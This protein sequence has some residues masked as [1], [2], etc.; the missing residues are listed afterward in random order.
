MNIF[1]TAAQIYQVPIL[2]VY[3]IEHI[4]KRS[5]L[6][7]DMQSKEHRQGVTGI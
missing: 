5:G 6:Y 2:F 1:G 7:G 3:G 4:S